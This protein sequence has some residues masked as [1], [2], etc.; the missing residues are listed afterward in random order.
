MKSPSEGADRA[1]ER[2]L[3][4]GAQDPGA[5][6]EGYGV[7]FD[8]AVTQRAGP[9]LDYGSGRGQGLD[10]LRGRGFTEVHA[11][12][13]NPLLADALRAKTS[14]VH[15]HESPQAFLQE[16][17]GRFALILCKDVLEHVSKEHASETVQLLLNALKPGGRLVVSVPHAVSFVG[18][19]FRY[20]DFTHHTAFT[21]SSLRYVLESAGAT[22]VE[23]YSPRFPFRPSPKT[24]AYRLLKRCWHT[25]LKGIYYL[26]N[27]DPTG[28]PPHFHPRLVA[29]CEAP[30][31]PT[32]T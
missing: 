23:F 15:L 29:S 2:Q 25:A 10:Y 12:E 3:E 13:P 28:Q 17:P 7:W 22:K 6:L 16:N 14:N 21:E 1:Y 19:Y 30:A 24:I 32:S 5:A 4:Q 26:E 31:Q 27:P 20:A 8:D 18:V 9:A 11:Y